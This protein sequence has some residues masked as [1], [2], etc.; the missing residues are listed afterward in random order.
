MK[1]Q[2]AVLCTVLLWVCAVFAPMA[3]AA[4]PALSATEAYCIID[5]DTGLVLAQQNM[6]EELHPASI[7]KVMTLALACEKAQGSWNGVKL[8]VSHEDVHSLAGTDSSHIALQEGEEVPLTDALYATQMAS[9]NDGA[10]LLAE[11]FGGGTSPTAWQ[12]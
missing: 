4:G 8:T 6:N 2:I 9:A 3:R 7:T 1:K 12:R 11:Y 5:A 10:N